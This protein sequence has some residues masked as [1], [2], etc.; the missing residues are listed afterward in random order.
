M[1]TAHGGIWYLEIHRSETAKKGIEADL[2]P[3]GPVSARFVACGDGPGGSTA[4]IVADKDL[5]EIWDKIRAYPNAPIAVENVR[6]ATGEDVAAAVRSNRFMRTTFPSI[7][8]IDSGEDLR[9]FLSGDGTP[10]WA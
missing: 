3:D 7:P 5:E 4:V 1:S 6:P 9:E 8:R 10:R 2:P